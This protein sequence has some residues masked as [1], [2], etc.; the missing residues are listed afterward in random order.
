MNDLVCK[1][2]W[3]WSLMNSPEEA[4]FFC[5]FYIRTHFL[6]GWSLFVLNQTIVFSRV[7][8]CQVQTWPVSQSSSCSLQ[9]ESLHF[10]PYVCPLNPRAL[11]P[12]LLVFSDDVGWYHAP[13]D[14]A[15]PLFFLVS[16]E[17]SPCKIMPSTPGLHWADLN[18]RT[19]VQ[20]RSGGWKG[21]GKEA[22]PTWKSR[23]PWC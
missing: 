17:G 11:S 9:P 6:K 16:T 4:Y 5:S 10:T 23:E 18:P 13:G 12:I 21:S 14:G 7:F 15:E 1:W 2:I 3:I 8:H 20:S 19:Q 22:V